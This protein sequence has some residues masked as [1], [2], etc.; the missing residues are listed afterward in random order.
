MKEKTALGKCYAVER[1][2]R[3]LGR[4]QRDGK[5]WM[6]SS[7]YSSL[8][9]PSGLPQLTSVA[10]TNTDSSNSPVKRFSRDIL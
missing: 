7:T 5:T 1:P 9:A 8:P 2:S 10:L 4:R 3:T 6:R